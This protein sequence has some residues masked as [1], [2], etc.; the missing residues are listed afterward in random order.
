MKWFRRLSLEGNFLSPVFSKIIELTSTMLGQDRLPRFAIECMSDS[1][2]LHTP[3]R[4]QLELSNLKNCFITVMVM[5]LIAVCVLLHEMSYKKSMKPV[6][7][8][9]KKCPRGP[10]CRICATKT[11]GHGI[12]PRMRKQVQPSSSQAAT[13]EEYC[14]KLL[15]YAQIRNYTLKIL[16]TMLWSNLRSLAA[17]HKCRQVG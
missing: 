10:R 9:T 16:L 12:Y 2:V 1:L 14:K 4:D 11:C 3:E 5:V 15:R 8:K 13:H 7:S 17:E 6:R